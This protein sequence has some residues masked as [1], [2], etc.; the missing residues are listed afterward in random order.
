MGALFEIKDVLPII[1]A[2]G[3]EVALVVSHSW[4][5][6]PAKMILLGESFDTPPQDFGYL[7]GFI[8]HEDMSVK[9]F[10]GTKSI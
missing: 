10:S 3:E 2:K 8:V 9:P 6:A 1:K 5:M 7:E 4:A